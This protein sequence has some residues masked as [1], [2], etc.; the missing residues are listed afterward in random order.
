MHYNKSHYALMLAGGEGSRLRKLTRMIAGDE[1]PKQFC[2][3]VNGETL[4]D[5]TRRRVALVI[6]PAR[7]HFSLTARHER[8]FRPILGDLPKE[9]L[10]I[11]PENRGTAP[12]IV[13]NLLR[14]ARND[15][16]ASV[17]IFP[18]DH[19]LSDDKR[20]MEKVAIAF[21]ATDLDPRT[22][23][24]LGIEPESAETSYGWIEPCE[25]LFGGLP[26]SISRV[27]RFWE[28]PT[29]RKARE[30]EARGCLWNSFVMVGKVSTM[31]S[32]IERRLPEM[33]RVFTAAS[34]SFDSLGEAATMR[35]VY[36]SIP[37]TNFSSEVLERSAA[38]LSVLRV[39]DVTWR[40]LG[41][42]ARV[43]G[44]LNDLGIRP[45][46]VTATAA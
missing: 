35:S 42:P 34:R 36:A 9:R 31:L 14:I 24:L 38:D 22:V 25:S 13:F 26:N 21:Q 44:T 43:I 20:F 32:L 46:W 6:D 41:E 45:D 23:A 39:A 33:I 3:I 17:A 7:T 18:S 2:P 1:R 27:R 19:Y 10:A 11:Q 5:V 16:N 30:L 8:F 37:E 12:A 40:D 4:L 28:K 29:P 15:A